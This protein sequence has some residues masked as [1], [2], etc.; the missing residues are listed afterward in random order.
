MKRFIWIL[1]HF[2]ITL[3]IHGMNFRQITTAD[4]LTNSAILSLYSDSNGLLWIGTCDGLNISDGFTV[5]PARQIP[6]FASISGNIIENI[7]ETEPGT[8]WV[9]TNYGLNRIST[10]SNSFK[11]FPQFQGQEKIIVAPDHTLFVL[12]EHCDLS[13]CSPGDEQFTKLVNLQLDFSGIYDILITDALMRLYTQG[14]IYDYSISKE[15]NGYRIGK[16]Q[17]ASDLNMRSARCDNTYTLAV[18]TD[19]NLMQFNGLAK[20]GTPLSNIHDDLNNRGDIS[21]M[22]VDDNGSIFISFRTGGLIKLTRDKSNAY[23]KEDLGVDIGVFCLE[24]SPL[25]NVVWAG[26]DCHGVYT[27]FDDPFTLR[28]LG[29]DSFA[30]KIFHPVRSVYL[31]EFNSLWIG[32]KGDGL[33]RVRNFNPIPGNSHGEQSL[34][35]KG[36]SGLSDNSVYAVS[37]SSRPLL[38]I[39]EDS[40][41]DYFS[42]SDN[43]I[44]K[45]ETRG[46]PVNLVHGIY[47][48]NDTTLFIST[49]GH[50]IFKARISG[51]PDR[52]IL[53]DIRQYTIDGGNLSSNY[54]FAQD[55]DEDTAPIFGNR[56]FGIFTLR[57][58][59]L[60][61]IHDLNALS[62]DKAINDVFAVMRDKGNIWVGT[63]SGLVKIAPDASYLYAG[64]EN[65]FPNNTIHAMLKD[66]YDN[67]WIST[68][69]G[70]VRFN[71]KTE[72]THTYLTSYNVSG[73]EF[74]DGAAHKAGD[75][76]MFGGVDG[77]FMLT[78]TSP[79]PPG[80]NYMPPMQVIGLTVGGQNEPIT[81][82]IS[83]RMFEEGECNL[84]LG[85]DQNYFSVILST[86]D[87][88]NPDNYIFLY[89]LDGEKWISNGT[90]RNLSFTKLNYGKNRLRIKYRNRETGEESREYVMNINIQ[91][92]WYLSWWAKTLYF[93]LL[94]A[95]VFVIIRIYYLHQRE[96]QRS[97][98]YESKMKFF[99]N[100]S[101]ELF[102]PLT[103]IY[104]TGDRLLA[105]EETSPQARKHINLIMSNTKRLNTLIQELVDFRKIESGHRKLV[106]EVVDISSL[107]N[108]ICES[109]SVMAEHNGVT[110]IK[111][112]AEGIIF[113]TDREAFIRILTNLLSNA[114]KYTPA[115]GTVK[116]TIRGEQGSLKLDIYNT[117][118]GISQSD[119]KKIF[120]RFTILDNMEKNATKGLLSR[121]GLG[122][123]I[124][125]SLVEMLHGH[126]DIES[127]MGH[128]ALFRVSLPP[129]TPTPAALTSDPASKESFVTYEDSQNDYLQMLTLSTEGKPNILVVDDNKDILSFLADTLTEYNIITALTAE[130]GINLVKTLNIDLIITDVMLPDKNGMTFTRYIKSNK[131]TMYIPVVI[132]SGKHATSEKVEGLASGA[133]VY[134]EKPF[135]LR[136]LRAVIYRLLEKQQSMQEYYNSSASGFAYANGRL[137]SKESKDF[138]SEVISF[139][140]TNLEDEKLNADAL[141]QHMQIGVRNLYRRFKD[142]E[143]PPPNEFIKAH[144]LQIAA[145]L[146]VTTSL[147]VQE[148]IYR[149][150]FNNR[151][152]FYREFFR[153]Y[154]M[155]PKDYRTKNK[156]KSDF[157]D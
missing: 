45:V 91:S 82:H 99:S 52:P 137:Q 11:L 43:S 109:F 147:T 114:F 149:S 102:T 98:T 93:L 14:G 78:R 29:F 59:S 37:H 97:D 133:D 74:S 156:K 113:N 123:A 47:E 104:G 48:A 118:K 10:R 2:A 22:V 16:P 107:A 58:N 124:C 44:H 19:G 21:D 35:T 31:D 92:P 54:F 53:T 32:T 117:G 38:W 24:K 100:I 152:H 119:K 55:F 132:L 139:I 40:G 90:S 69:K 6:E 151:S 57:D 46:M 144:K 83:N 111:D 12:N 68:N 50:G 51:A 154:S 95:I 42:Y 131:H 56:G 121:N 140:D 1:L 153:H 15:A 72:D 60:Q 9:Q 85:P 145:K 33:L 120:N 76:L 75:I 7:V 3:S 135:D 70:L 80:V 17:K 134:I 129:N 148:V 79:V 49:T 25:Q 5:F 34:F 73:N 130:E 64:L 81:K 39:A 96:K 146:L 71:T 89:T 138:I 128:Y 62:G 136:Y 67:I 41:I 122:L 27:F 36:N 18:D 88:T 63:G 77:L 141:A 86:P 65:G 125:K 13:Y 94:G 108:E 28:F 126:I 26:S 155:T 8:I 103:L 4:G 20:S 61:S 23:H 116:L 105:D 143:L 127:E 115:E 142:L 84:T 112:I 101:H 110:F 30:N 157:E 150:G 66:D 106:I 87:F